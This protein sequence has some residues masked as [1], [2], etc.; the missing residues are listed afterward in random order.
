MAETFTGSCHCGG[1]AY[2]VTGPLR[3]IIGCHCSQCR[4]TSGHHVAATA[5][6]RA[7]FRLTNDETLA[8][9]DASAIARRGFCGRCGGNLFWSRH[10]AE[11]I[12]IMAGTLDGAVELPFAKHIFVNDK[13]AWMEIPDG[14]ETFDEYSG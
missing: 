12:T 5:A 3:E 7:D 9:Y 11:T 8:W 6:A 13:S 4:K 14:A 1:V 2:E 10:G